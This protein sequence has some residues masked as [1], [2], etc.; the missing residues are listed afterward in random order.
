MSDAGEPLEGPPPTAPR[1]P[2]MPA[3]PRRPR[4]P[5]FPWVLATTGL[6][7]LALAW[8]ATKGDLGA[9][10]AAPPQAAPNEANQFETA[11]AAIHDDFKSLTQRVDAFQKSL[12]GLKKQI[13][14]LPKPPEMPDLKPI[15][16][17]LAAL[18]HLPEKLHAATKGTEK[19]VTELRHEVTGIKGSLEKSQAGLQAVEE[20][21]KKVT[22]AASER[23]ESPAEATAKPRL[24]G[25]DL[26]RGVGLFKQAQYPG[27][28]A[29]FRKLSEQY[30]RDARVWYYAALSNGF[31]TGN[32]QGETLQFANRGV[33]LEKAGTP[34]RAAIDAALNGLAP[35]TAQWIAAFR[36]RAR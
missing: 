26:L 1:P 10:A 8:I 29:E 15:E 24:A 13:D 18:E 25:D 28:A 31:T 23:N 34:D 33:E 4:K 14:D 21:I 35:Q 27:A 5:L 30:P 36:A 9:P 16:T 7:V 19:S 6:A 32:W 20:H 11:V 17:R 3:P 12:D 2:M 22:A